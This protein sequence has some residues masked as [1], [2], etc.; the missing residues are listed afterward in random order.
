MDKE[1]RGLEDQLVLMQRLNVTH[2]L[3]LVTLFS[4]F[5]LV[6]VFLWIKSREEERLMGRKIAKKPP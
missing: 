3:R 6:F 2:H 1:T 4:P 5:V